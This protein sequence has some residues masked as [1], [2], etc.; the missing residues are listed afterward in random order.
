MLEERNEKEGVRLKGERR[1]ECRERQKQ[2]NRER[3]R[4]RR[5]ETRGT[6]TVETLI[7]CSP[8]V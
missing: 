8:Y 1:E 7:V 6:R 2:R 5:S 3:K 4:V